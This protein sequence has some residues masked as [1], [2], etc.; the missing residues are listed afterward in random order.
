M[1]RKI[2]IFLIVFMSVSLVSEAQTGEALKCIN[3]N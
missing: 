2:K 1:I 3:M